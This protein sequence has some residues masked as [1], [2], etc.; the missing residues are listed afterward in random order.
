MGSLIETSRGPL[1]LLF[2]DGFE[3]RARQGSFARLGAQARRAA[4]FVYRTARRNQGET[5]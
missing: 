1:V 5:R 4:R 3:W 2:Y